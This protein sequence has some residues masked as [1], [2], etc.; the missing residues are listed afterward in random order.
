MDIASTGEAYGS[1]EARSDPAG[2][3]HAAF[4]GLIASPGADTLIS[5]HTPRRDAYELVV[6]IIRPDRLKLRHRGVLQSDVQGLRH[7][8][9]QATAAS[10]ETW[11]P[12]RHGPSREGVVE[13]R[14]SGFEIGV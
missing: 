11:K 3:Q 14:K 10:A 13:K 6:A 2:P 8:R 7:S 1:G 12:T 5:V 9:V 4:A